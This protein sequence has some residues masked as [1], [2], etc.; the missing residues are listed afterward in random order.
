MFVQ[1]HWLIFRQTCRMMLDSAPS[2][3]NRLRQTDFSA[4]TLVSCHLTLLPT[5]SHVQ[6]ALLDLDSAMRADS[7]L[8]PHQ[9]GVLLLDKVP[10]SRYLTT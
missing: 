3:D 4:R 5:C 10:R 2:M 6:T 7:T 8:C 1:T 9:P